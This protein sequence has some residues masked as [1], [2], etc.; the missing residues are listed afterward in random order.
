MRK[1]LGLLVATC[2]CLIALSG[3]G[4]QIAARSFG[5]DVTLDLEPGQKLVDITWKEE[6]LWYLTK[7]MIETDIAEVYTFQ[8]SSLF[9]VFEGTVT[10]Q[11]YIA[12]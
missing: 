4:S 7:P 3:C 1:R 8:Q 10:V 2:A 6:S 12:E 9:G 5:G 11:E